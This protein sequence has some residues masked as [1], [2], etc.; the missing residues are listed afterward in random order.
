MGLQSWAKRCICWMVPAGPTKCC[1]IWLQTR[2][3]WPRSPLTLLIS[4]KLLLIW[5]YGL[6]SYFK[7]SLLSKESNSIHCSSGKCNSSEFLW[8]QIAVLQFRYEG[9]STST[10]PT[11]YSQ[12]SNIQW[13]VYSDAWATIEMWHHSSSDYRVFFCWRNWQ[14]Q[15]WHCLYGEWAPVFFFVFFFSFSFLFWLHL[16]VC[17]TPAICTSL[18]LSFRSCPEEWLFSMGL[19]RFKWGLLIPSRAAPCHSSCLWVWIWHQLWKFWLSAF[20]PVKM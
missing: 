7:W 17:M 2:M 11:C 1:W 10:S 18:S 14:L 19:R 15:C 5:W 6:F 9:G 8:L 13:T 4:I 16:S 12:Q 20:C 3:D